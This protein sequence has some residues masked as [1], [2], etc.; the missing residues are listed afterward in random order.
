MGEKVEKI[1]N[2]YFTPP[3]P[4]PI[5]VL[6]IQKN[7]YPHLSKIISLFPFCAEQ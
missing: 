4:P 3:L 7:I 6:F 1:E 2:S 5:I